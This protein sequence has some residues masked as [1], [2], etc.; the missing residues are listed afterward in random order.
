MP[1]LAPLFGG[2][3]FAGTALASMASLGGFGTLALRLG[4]SLLLSAASRALMP[5]PTLPARTVT[6]REAVAPRDMVYGRARKGGVIVYISE[7]GPKRQYLH[8]VVV[9]AA[10]QVAA[11]GAVYFD[12]EAAVDATGTAL[13]RWADLVTVEKR[14]GTDDQIAFEGLIAALPE[15][16]TTAHRLRGCAAIHLRLQADQDAFPG[17]IP[18]ISVDITGKNDIF[19]PR[20]DL[21][22]YSENPALCLADYM[23]HARFGLGAAIGASDGI[24]T[25]ALIEA[26]NICDE[27][28]ALAAGGT[29]PRYSCNGV[30]SLAENPKT[31]IEAM[32]TAMAGRVA[33]SGG[34]WRLHAGAYRMPEF[35]LTQDHAREG[36]L[37]LST[38]ISAAQNF[39]GVRGQ[40]ISP[41][42]DW[43]PD[44]FPAYVSAVYRAEDGGEEKWRDI[45]LPFTQ[46]ATTAQR[47]AKI[48]LERA[49]R[50]MSIRFAGKL[51]AWAVQVGDTVALTYDRWGMAAKPYEVI[52]A[53]LDLATSGD[54]PQLLPELVLRET[55]PFVYDWDAS[56]A[57]IYA[58]APR[59]TLP[60][61]FTVAPP[62]SPE[63]AE[64]LYITRDGAGVKAAVQVSWR[65]SDSAYVAQYQ[66]ESR[67]VDA[68]GGALGS[69]AWTNH[70]RTDATEMEIRDIAPGFWEF[71]VK[72]L[73]V[74]GVSSAWSVT[75][76]EVLALTA[77]P[78]ALT[79]VTLQTA[80]GMAILKWT[81]S[82]DLDVRIGGNIVIR[83]SQAPSATWA[84]SQSFDIVAGSD[85]IAVV[86]LLPGTYL[87]RARDSS[88]VLGDVVSLSTSGAQALA[89]APVMVLMGE[90]DFD[91]VKSGTVAIDGTL[92]LDAVT[93]F[94]DWANVDAVTGFDRVGGTVSSGSFTFASGM[95]FG[96]LRRLRLRSHILLS[97]AGV[98]DNLDARSEVIDLWPDFDGSL[99]A[100]VDAVI[101]ARSTPDDPTGAPLWSEWGR[102]DSHEL[103]ARG[104]QARAQ[105]STRDP[106]WVP[107]VSQLRLYADEVA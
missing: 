23:A 77:P 13:G 106:V 36:G 89:F 66:L 96:T 18:A 33:Y 57:A 98:L 34:Q 3:W 11:I 26:A 94:D 19:D 37:T 65:G 68:L 82:A 8:L 51:S 56:E 48:E 63:I 15:A 28:V 73:T 7:A 91:G 2:G 17:G 71:R 58:A 69:G 25:D 101:E 49:R 55:S 30:V 32:L 62:G 29:E 84:S 64:S 81:R 52:E 14:L 95:D 70:G 54:G 61:A 31:I 88:G 103:L 85:A 79:G 83:H 6:V 47:L 60:S 76:K 45:A 40:F 12:G 24:N 59:S 74:L 92:T 75:V 44:D 80:G 35:S 42:N 102:V 39:N 104:I 97:A 4:A 38:R 107:L 10:H 67:M 16:W 72:A 5:G 100:E 41:E 9:L 90:P 99:E 22:G 20:S 78:A 27:T 43:Q 93:P 21:A 1:F 53:R 87:L 105:L 46:S 86:P 50:Q